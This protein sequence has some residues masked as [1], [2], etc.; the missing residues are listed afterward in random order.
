VLWHRKRE[1]DLDRELQSHLELETEERGGDHLAAR[2][3]FGN[4]AVI[5]EDT[6]A[7]WGWTGWKQFSRDLHL[8]ARMLRRRPVFACVAI[9]SLA[10]GIGAN[11]AIF[12]FANAIL[13]RTLPVAGANRLVILRQH[14]EAFR[15]ENCCLREDVLRRLQHEDVG[16][17]DVLGVSDE[18]V[19]V[20]DRGQ[21]ERLRAEFVT[22]NYFSMLGV[23]PA[24]GRLFEAKD[25]A[26]GAAVAVI[27]YNLWTERFRAE[28][29]AIGRRIEIDGVSFQIIGVTQPGFAGLSLTAP[30]DL[31]IPAAM[32]APMSHGNGLEAVGRLRPG[33]SEKQ[34][35]AR[36]N[37]VARSIQREVGLRVSDKDDFRFLDGSQGLLSSKEEFGR[38]VLI[39]GLL[40]GV[41]LL[42]TCANLT[43]LLLVRSVE[44]SN[45]AGMR[46]AL[47]ASRF[48]LFRQF[49]AESLILSGLGG[50][51]AWGIAFLLVGA[52]SGYLSENPNL[53]AQVRPDATVF[54]FSA[55]ITLVAALMFGTFPAWQ[56]S[57]V[58]PLAAVHGASG[59]S[60]RRALVSRGIVSAQV[61]LSLVL[62]FC[63]G[64]FTRTLTNLRSIDLG[65]RPENLIF[66]Q[67]LLEGTPHKG[68]GAFPF[69]QELLRRTEELPT[70][71]AA[72]LGVIS[73]LSGSTLAW[74]L[75]I[76]GYG[77][78]GDP[79]PTAL[80]YYVSNGYFRT[81][82]IPLLG[83]QDFPREITPKDADS[84]IVN[85][86]FARRYFG[87]EALGKSFSMGESKR[88]VIGVVDTTKYGS[89][90]EEPQPIFYLPIS[91]EIAPGI[92]QVRTNGNPEQ[93]IAQMRA[94]I[95]TIDPSVSINSMFTMEARIDEILG[96]ERL[97]AFLSTML[98]GVAVGLSAIGLYGVLAFSVVRRT[99]EIGI[100]IAV[101]ASRSGVVLMFLKEGGWLVGAGVLLGVPLAL[102]CG[103][104]AE[105]LLYGLPPQDTGTMAWAMGIMLVF[106]SA[107]AVIPAWRA[108]RLSTVRALRHE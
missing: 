60:R 17:E 61:A 87:N 28:P 98:G 21:S 97:L 52:L 99:R 31:Q 57:K 85:E 33:V 43:A 51:A 101:G 16:F 22:S 47:G 37:T 65:F 86:E 1:R 89:L 6:R 29:D 5:Q 14:N 46:V 105:S 15:R 20:R 83:G 19:Q 94:L 76:P 54:V 2:R 26:P 92:I 75:N 95:Q 80:M 45:E 104:A 44:R 62:L 64:L 56:A 58:D 3:A 38:P 13:I 53:P 30:R 73:P 103:R 10:I 90:R 96:R 69:F 88:Q 50:T 18:G 40:V 107:A 79:R 68:P 7:T 102:A 41:V 34:A 8:A 100:R 55:V 74:S 93:G 36:L 59:G 78:P 25:D 49:F 11:T 4:R 77:S 71:R 70:V 24:G 106:A 81:L 91:G 82:G 12:S 42:V 66:L 108:A 23:R 35:L 9:F 63:A 48:A 72:S 67:P 84:V 27:S 39:L 32:M